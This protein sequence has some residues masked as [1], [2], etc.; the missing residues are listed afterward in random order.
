MN[1]KHEGQGGLSPP[2]GSI[3]SQESES[4]PEPKGTVLEESAVNDTKS[5]TSDDGSYVMDSRDNEFIVPKIQEKEK[6]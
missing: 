3:Y 2:T 6:E 4:E 5:Q 1:T